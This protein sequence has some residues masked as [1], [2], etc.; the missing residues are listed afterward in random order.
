MIRN[1]FIDAGIEHIRVYAFNSPLENNNGKLYKEIVIKNNDDLSKLF[2]RFGIFKMFSNNGNN[3][4]NGEP[5][6]YI[7]GKLSEITRKILGRGETIIPSAA[8][9]AAAKKLISHGENGAPETLGIIDL[10]AS[11]YMVICID[12]KGDLKDDLLIT[13]PRCGA[14]TGVNLSRILQKLDI[15]W[16]EVDQILSD[17]LG[18]K[19]REKRLNTPVRS[20]RCGVFSS[21][22]TISDKNQGIPLDY[23]LAVTMKSEILK[24]CKKI[25]GKTE[26]VYLTGGVFKWQFARDCA[27]DFF[28][29]DGVKE[30][31]YENNHS[32]LM[33]GMQYLVKNIGNDNFRKQNLISLTKPETLLEIPSFQYLKEK[34]KNKGL[35]KRLPDPKT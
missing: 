6:I 5:A 29:E 22:A 7:S 3:L 21:S 8:L 20:D 30:I 32:I 19:G 14:G 27:T 2:T 28:K 13:N 15:R 9:W 16:E 4:K 1:V 18:D 17:Y 26:K 23:A 34:Y 31:V 35:F 25:S 10:S 11:G 33:T 12:K 24:P